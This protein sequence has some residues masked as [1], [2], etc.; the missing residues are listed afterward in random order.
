MEMVR[1]RGWA[2]EIF[3]APLLAEMPSDLEP[4]SRISPGP[5]AV[6]RSASLKWMLI[7]LIVTRRLLFSNHL[8]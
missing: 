1:G 8:Q 3:S 6:L 7:Q 5:P 2:G 4:P